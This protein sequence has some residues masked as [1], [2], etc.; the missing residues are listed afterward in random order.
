MKEK[1][2]V[3]MLPTNEKSRLCKDNGSWYYDNNPSEFSQFYHLFLLS[4]DPIQEGDWVFEN[5]MKSVV[6]IYDTEKVKNL[7][8]GNHLTK[9]IAT[10]DSSLKN[11]VIGGT[12]GVGIFE[13]NLPKPSDE[14]IKQFCQKGGI[15]EVMVEYEANCDKCSMLKDCQNSQ[16]K[17]DCNTFCRRLKIA[18]DNTISISPVKDSWNRDEVINLIE[19]FIHSHPNGVDDEDFDKWIEEN[20]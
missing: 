12:S 14:F 3:V 16:R 8:N 4:D 19:N 1:C 2:K 7:I 17:I 13:Q 6:Q 18:H 9:I 11:T 5:I 15:W 10:T 20:L